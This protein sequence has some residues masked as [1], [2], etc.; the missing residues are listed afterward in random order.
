MN[1]L[2]IFRSSDGFLRAITD[3]ELAPLAWFLEQ[4]VQNDE[5]SCREIIE[6]CEKIS[7]HGG[8]WELAG[9]AHSI[10]ITQ[11]KVAITNDYA[12][13]PNFCEVAI[14]DFKNSM[15]IWHQHIANLNNR[16]R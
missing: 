2:T 12:P 16:N 14:N 9:N 15:A 8:S 13:P 11:D 6:A 4:D 7:T 10:I 1:R 5:Q 3:P